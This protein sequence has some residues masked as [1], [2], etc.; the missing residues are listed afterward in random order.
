[1][2]QIHEWIHGA[3]D[4]L[5]SGYEGLDYDTLNDTISEHKVRLVANA[6]N[7]YS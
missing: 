6:S 5:D 2:K 3:E 7:F 4:M 1:M